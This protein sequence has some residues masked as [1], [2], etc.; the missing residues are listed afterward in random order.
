[1]CNLRDVICSL[2]TQ[3][4]SDGR[5]RLQ[6]YVF[7][8]LQCSIEK[9]EL[10]DAPAPVITV[11]SMPPLH[12]HRLLRIRAIVLREPQIVHAIPFI[13]NSILR[14]TCLDTMAG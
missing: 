3:S 1:M 13:F 8:Q 14:M 6:S 10:G 5:S 4:E 7:S 2:T 9:L 11:N 12:V